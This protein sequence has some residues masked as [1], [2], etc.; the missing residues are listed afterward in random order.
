[1][2]KTPFLSIDGQKNIKNQI[3]IENEG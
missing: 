3:V 1:M 2:M